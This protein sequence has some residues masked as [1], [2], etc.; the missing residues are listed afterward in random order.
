MSKT[1]G[2]SGKLIKD[3]GIYA[4]G[5]LGSKLVTFLLVPLYTYYV[6]PAEYGYYDLSL[7]AVFLMMPFLSLMLRDGAFRFLI[8]SDDIQRRRSIVTFVYKTLFRNIIIAAVITVFVAYFS[9]FEYLW[10]IL[11]LLI[12]M[13]VY[14]VAIQ[15]IRGL[16]HTKYFVTAGILSSLMIGVFSILFVVVLEMG[17]LGIFWANI[18]ARIVT[19]LIIDIRLGIFRKYFVY[20]FN[21]KKINKEI[22]R[23][24]LPLLPGSICWWLVGCSNKLFIEH[25][26][27][28]DNNGLYAV[29]LKFTAILETFAFIFY[30]AWQETALRQYK[31]PDRDKFFSNILNNYIF[32]LTIAAIIFA[33]FLKLNYFWL[34]DTSYRSSVCYIFPLAVS[35]MFFSLSAFFDMGYQCSKKTLYTLPGVIVA[36]IINVVGNY[37]LIKEYQ[38]YGIIGSSILTFASL[39]IYRLI[40][41]RKFFRITFRKD[42]IF[43]AII[44][45]V[46]G[47]E[48]YVVD[49]V[50]IQILYICTVIAISTLIAPA[51]VKTLMSKALGKIRP[52]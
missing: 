6:Q 43:A 49:S 7:T 21:D 12:A 37:F 41:T 47:I 29:A 5:N 15:V 50:L 44:L 8:E 18:V 26:L 28:L 3:I 20:K 51:D 4:I 22:L 14:E 48:Y 52:K 31:S 11:G 32:I 34:V 39:F 10:S 38:V 42:A 9:S 36:S 1:T 25:Y 13:S 33:T 16:G 30:Q 35:T 23:Y 40:D 27:G 19:I 17:I 2:R 45:I 46:S 24:C